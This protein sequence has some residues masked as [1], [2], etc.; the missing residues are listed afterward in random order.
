VTALRA[1][2]IS[3]DWREIGGNMEMIAALAVNVAGFPVA[4]V[5]DRVQVAL[6]AAGVV[7]AEEAPMTVLVKAV[8]ETLARR[9]K[10]AKLRE[11][12]GVH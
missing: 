8:V 2:D 12:V 10:M 9:D 7:E 5:R 6:V 4:A 11:R 1:S 3:G